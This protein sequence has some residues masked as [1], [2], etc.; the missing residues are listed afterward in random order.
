[1]HRVLLELVN[2]NY[3]TIDMTIDK[4]IVEFTAP[5]TK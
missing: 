5:K 3:L 1:V 4:G 2:A